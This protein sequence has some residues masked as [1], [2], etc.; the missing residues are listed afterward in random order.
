MIRATLLVFTGY[1]ASDLGT[2]YYT[3]NAPIVDIQIA[4]VNQIIYYC[5]A[6]KLIHLTRS[7]VD[8]V[9]PHG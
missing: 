3:S 4:K 2:A 6:Q 8:I 5:V 7:R 9:W 1:L